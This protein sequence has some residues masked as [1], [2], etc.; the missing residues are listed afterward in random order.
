MIDIMQTMLPGVASY[1][2]CTEQHHCDIISR[3]HNR[4]DA[5]NAAW[6]TLLKAVIIEPR[7]SA[8]Q[9]T[10]PQD[11]YQATDAYFDSVF[12]IGQLLTRHHS[13]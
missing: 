6:G 11:V 5:N 3:N 2:R 4:L 1:Q 9:V 13:G 8:V 7:S 10:T 12:C